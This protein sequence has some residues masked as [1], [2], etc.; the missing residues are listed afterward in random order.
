MNKLILLFHDLRP[1][2]YMTLLGRG[3]NTTVK[4]YPSLKPRFSVLG[5]VLHERRSLEREALVQG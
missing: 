2:H 1:V 3:S 4:T 5:F